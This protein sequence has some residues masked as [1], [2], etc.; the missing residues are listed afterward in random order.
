MKAA[1]PSQR[2]ATGHW[3]GGPAGDSSLEAQND[4]PGQLPSIAPTGA[5]I[6]PPKG[7]GILLLGADGFLGGNF[8]RYFESHGRPVHAIGRAAGDLTDP[9]VADGIFATAPKVNRIFHLVTR[10]RTGA[11]QYDIQGELLAINSRIHLNVLEAWRRHQPQAK[12]ITAGSSCAYPESDRP[13]AESAFQTGPLHPSVE[14]Y[15]LAKQLLAVGCDVYA[16][17]YG[18]HYLHCILATVYGPKDHKEPGRSHFMTALLDRAVREM[19]EGG[20]Q[21]TVWG[22]PGTV[23][24]LLYVD[25]EIEAVLAA[26]ARFSDTILNCAANQPVTIGEVAEAI[27]GVLDWHAEITYPAD[28]FQGTSFK[29]LDSSRFLQATGWKPRF[30]LTKGLRLTLAEDYGIH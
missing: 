26:D 18:L 2:Q 19:R 13:L 20:R 8:R 5:T 15:G 11:I 23:R 4:S 21:F 7:N 3:S 10:Q 14:G 16:K 29:V 6:A 27:V 9:A 24:E 30:P 22:Q 25:D 1:G 28:S 12:L 17:Q